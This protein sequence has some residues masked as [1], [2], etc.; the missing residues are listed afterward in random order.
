MFLVS[1][2]HH[3]KL[4]ELSDGN[5]NWKQKPIKLLSR[6]SHHFWVMGDRN[7]IM[8]DRNNKSKQSLSDW[9]E[10][11][12]SDWWFSLI[13]V[14]TCKSLSFFLIQVLLVAE[15]S[16]SVKCTF[17]NGLPTICLISF[18]NETPSNLTWE[19]QEWQ[20]KAFDCDWRRSSE[21]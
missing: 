9:Q 16:P 19:N 1:I 3:S 18:L 8:S 7:R 21:S 2:T 13:L 6:G 5:K 15:L 20:E 14:I 4:R 12:D 11:S 10:S 17:I